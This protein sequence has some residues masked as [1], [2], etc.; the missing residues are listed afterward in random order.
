[1]VKHVERTTDSTIQ[2]S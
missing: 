1:M 2:L